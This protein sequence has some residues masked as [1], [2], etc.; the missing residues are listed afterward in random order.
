M[1]SITLIELFQLG[2]DRLDVSNKFLAVIR[3]PDSLRIPREQLDFIV[4]FFDNDGWLI[5]SACAAFV[6]FIY[7]ATL[8]KAVNC[9]DPHNRC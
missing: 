3:E 2:Q 8:A 5:R 6:M 1:E 9:R 7:L 4:F